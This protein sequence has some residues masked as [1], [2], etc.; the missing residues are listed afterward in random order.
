[1]NTF[2]WNL[3]LPTLDYLDRLERF[4]IRTFGHV[5]DLVNNIVALQYLPKN[6]M[7]PVKPAIQK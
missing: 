7:A 1:V 5:L 6:N 2:C 3:Q 4:I